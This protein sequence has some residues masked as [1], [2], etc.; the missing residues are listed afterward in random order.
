MAFVYFVCPSDG[1]EAAIAVVQ[2]AAKTQ[3]YR[4]F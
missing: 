2:Q 1:L 4:R 3:L